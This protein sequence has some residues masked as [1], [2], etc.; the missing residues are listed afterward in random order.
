MDLIPGRI[1]RIALEPTSTGVFRGA[2]AEYCGASH[3]H[4]HFYAVVTERPQF[5][6]WVQT[7]L[8]DAVTPAT[9]LALT[10]SLE[11][12]G[13]GC[14]ACHTVR[15]T[16]ASGRFGPDLTHLANRQSF[17]AGMFPVQIGQLQ[18][19]I[20]VTERVKPG[21]HMP[22]FNMIPPG[23]ARAIATYLSELR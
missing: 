20:Q 19:W 12:L 6:A 15:G 9:P 10:G 11:F 17:G 8:N 16:A 18:R 23:D 21:V 14:G 4:M 5:D 13:N 22:S 2:C 3:A 1:N 7:Q